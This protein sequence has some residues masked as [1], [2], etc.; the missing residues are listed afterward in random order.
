MPTLGSTHYDET[1]NTLKYASRA[2]AIRNAPMAQNKILPASAAAEIV[3]LK[4]TIS[5]L[6][7]KLENSS[8][9]NVGGDTAI[10]RLYKEKL[11]PMEIEYARQKAISEALTTRIDLLDQIVLSQQHPPLNESDDIF[12]SKIKAAF[13]DGVQRFVDRLEIRRKGIEQSLDAITTQMARVNRVISVDPTHPIFLDIQFLEK[14]R[15]IS[16]LQAGIDFAEKNTQMNDQILLEVA[17]VLINLTSSHGKSS[18]FEEAMYSFE[19]A[20]LSEESLYSAE[21]TV[22]ENLNI[23]Q[24]EGAILQSLHQTRVDVTDASE[25]TM[26][27]ESATGNTSPVERMSLGSVHLPCSQMKLLAEDK[28]IVNLESS[29]AKPIRMD[30]PDSADASL[31]TDMT[32]NNLP[33]Q[34]NVPQANMESDSVIRDNSILEPIAE[35]IDLMLPDTTLL[36]ATASGHSMILETGPLDSEEADDSTPK[37]SRFAALDFTPVE[38]R[39][40]NMLGNEMENTTRGSPNIS[41]KPDDTANGKFNLSHSS[42]QTG[43]ER[44]AL[45][46]PIRCS[47]AKRSARSK[48][49]SLIP[50]L[51]PSISMPSLAQP[52]VQDVGKNKPRKK[53]SRITAIQE[54]DEREQASPAPRRSTRRR[55]Q[56]T[57]F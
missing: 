54:V 44:V 4:A 19:M 16:G 49:R 47:P 43:L 31:V 46:G 32:G 37:A 9:L 45:S 1:L 56:V 36:N 24:F 35:H 6:K 7:S 30:P 50:V 18:A 10:G 53:A 27:M 28:K 5:K 39:A 22:I 26:D 40:F 42:L 20:L 52:H 33:V 17:K 38:V 21:G 12:K 41:K 13:Q 55:T 57:R 3:S 2:K 25:D 51:R 15:Q 23:P 29:A 8:S 48:R 34:E 14:D 11:I